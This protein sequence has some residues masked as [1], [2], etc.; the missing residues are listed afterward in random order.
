MDRGGWRSPWIVGHD[1]ATNTFT[2]HVGKVWCNQLATMWLAGLPHCSL[3]LTRAEDKR[4][5]KLHQF[6]WEEVCV[7]RPINSHPLSPHHHQLCLWTHCARTW[8]AKDRSWLIF[9]VW[10]TLLSRLISASSEM[11]KY[12][13]EIDKRKKSAYFVAAPNGLTTC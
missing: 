2:F 7:G 11:D 13:I 10:V 6:W 9:T 1:W 3:L 8:V 4:Q 5:Q 12:L